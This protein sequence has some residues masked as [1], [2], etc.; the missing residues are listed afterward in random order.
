[1][2]SVVRVAELHDNMSEE[3]ED[4]PGRAVVAPVVHEDYRSHC[5]Q[6]PEGS[7]L[8]LQKVSAV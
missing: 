7:L 6:C 4:V 5:F 8:E 1:M 3:G 2:D